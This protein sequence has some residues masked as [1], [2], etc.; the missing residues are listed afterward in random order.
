MINQGACRGP[1]KQV[2][3]RKQKEGTSETKEERGLGPVKWRL[4]EP[5]RGSMHTR[6]E[7]I[8]NSSLCAPAASYLPKD[9]RVNLFIQPAFPASCD[10]STWSPPLIWEVLADFCQELCDF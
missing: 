8:K 9:Y 4:K 3:F 7:N 6:I 10:L 5:R 2:S 1:D